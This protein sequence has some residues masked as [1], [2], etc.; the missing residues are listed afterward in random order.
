MSRFKCKDCGKSDYT[1]NAHLASSCDD[2]YE[3]RGKF[4]SAVRSGAISREMFLTTQSA[5]N[6]SRWKGASSMRHALELSGII[7]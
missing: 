1:P 5:M 7:P 2:C 6:N 4:M 3:L